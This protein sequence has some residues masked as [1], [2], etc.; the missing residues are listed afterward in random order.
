MI[1]QMRSVS[2]FIYHPIFCLFVFLYIWIHVWT[3]TRNRLCC[4]CCY[5]YQRE[6]IFISFITYSIL[7]LSLLLWWWKYISTIESWAN[8]S[9]KTAEK[10]NFSYL[11][12]QMIISFSCSPKPHFLF[13]FFIII[14]VSTHDVINFSYI[15]IPGQCFVIRWK[16]WIKTRGF[17]LSPP[18]RTS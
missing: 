3:G 16:Q 10:L 2:L 5:S 4:S 14:L 18:T 8:V 6:Q 11:R 9:V 12:K 13:F 1:F 15:Y 17:L 7:L